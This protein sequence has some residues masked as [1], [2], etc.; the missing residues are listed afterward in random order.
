MIQIK[1]TSIPVED[2][3]KALQFY[4]EILGFLKQQD[5]PMGEFR[6]LTVVSPASDEVE[7]LLE[8]MA[9]FP[10]AKDY[11]RGLYEAGIPVT[12]FTT[13]DIEHEFER[14]LK[15]GVRFKTPPTQMGPVTVAVFD[16][17]CG[18]YIQLFEV[19]TGE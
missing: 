8:P 13:D 1:L 15:H 16:D 19:G 14:L 3:E 18:N 4:T 12:G 17:T 6:F 11:F 7:L 10:P 5:I 2:Q 9:G